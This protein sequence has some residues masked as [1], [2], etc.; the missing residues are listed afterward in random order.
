MKKL[1][2]RNQDT[3]FLMLLNF[4]CSRSSL[5]KKRVT[6]VHYKKKNDPMDLKI[7]LISLISLILM[8]TALKGPSTYDV[9]VKIDFITPP[10]YVMVLPLKFPKNSMVR[11]RTLT[12]PFNHDIICG[13]PLINLLVKYFNSKSILLMI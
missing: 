11:P 7:S 1:I 8:R 4:Y 10:P 12:P 13:W 5:A 6:W 9:M 2:I 3:W